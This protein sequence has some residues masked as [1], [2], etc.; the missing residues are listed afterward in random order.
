MK[1]DS[2]NFKDLTSLVLCINSEVKQNRVDMVALTSMVKDIQKKIGLF[3]FLA[4]SEIPEIKV[5]LG[6]LDDNI[7][8]TMR[9]WSGVFENQLMRLEKMVLHQTIEPKK[10]KP[11]K[12]RGKK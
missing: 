10:H 8:E 1:E 4:L 11:K 6:R 5:R 7:G 12:K 3:Q 9:H 2:N